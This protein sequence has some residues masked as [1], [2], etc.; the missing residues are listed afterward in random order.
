MN[1][2]IIDAANEKIFL[3]IITNA[4]IYNITHDNTKINYEKLTIII[5][6]FLLSKNLKIADIG[7]IYINI[8]LASFAGIRNSMS[9][10]KAFNV[11]KNIDYYCY[12]LH[13]FKD[14]KNL[15]YERIPD[16]CKKYKIKKN[17]INP[18]YIS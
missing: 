6:D 12:N 16:L 4:S 8:G 2:L 15:S 5:N 9:V 7:I 18:I 11:A 1:K 17:L 10:V 3:M 13:D 14:E